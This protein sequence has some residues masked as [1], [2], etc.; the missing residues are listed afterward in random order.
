[1]IHAGNLQSQRRGFTLRELTVAIA[2]GST[3]MMTAVGLLNHSFRWSTLAQHRRTDDQTFF[4]LSRQLRADLHMARQAAVSNALQSDS[5]NTAETT[6]GLLTLTTDA[7]NVVTYTINER[8]VT[9]VETRQ[10]QTVGQDRYRWKRQRTLRFDRLETEDQIQLNAKSVTP[11]AESE[12]PLWRSLR[13]S[14][15][16]RLRHQSGDIAS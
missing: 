14:V 16:L 6:G 7:G 15:G 4:L 9:R 13:I 2:I 10:D 3:V 11:H 5:E 1:M 8:S 12:V